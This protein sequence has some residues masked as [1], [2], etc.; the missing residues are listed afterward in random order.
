MVLDRSVC[1][2]RII[3]QRASVR[4]LKTSLEEILILPNRELAIDL[5]VVEPER[6]LIGRVIELHGST[7][8]SGP[9]SLLNKFVERS[10][11]SGFL[12]RLYWDHH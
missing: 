9:A 10:G 1:T 6:G 7:F 4:D 8:F 2:R 11:L 5:S 12:L 3:G